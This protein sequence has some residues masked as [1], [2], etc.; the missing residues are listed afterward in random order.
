M[1]LTLNCMLVALLV[2]WASPLFG[3]VDALRQWSDATGKFNVQASLI[4]VRGQDVFLETADGKTM[5][6]PLSRLSQADQDFLK[7]DSNPF[8]EVGGAM[9]NLPATA[10]PAPAPSASDFA[11]SSSAA[12]AADNAPVPW[13]EPWNVDWDQVELM[14]SPFDT[15]WNY[16]PPATVELPFEAK[17]ATLP[18][19]TNFFEGMRRLEINPLAQRAVVGYTVTFSVPKPLSRISIIDLPSGK[20]LQS[21]AIESNMSP[22]AVL[23]DGATVLMQGS[24]K[25]R[26]DYETPDQLQLWRM[27]GK[28]IARSGI[29]Q[30]FAATDDTVGR[31]RMGSDS[32]HV[33]HAMPIAD[34]KIMLLSNERHLACF[35]VRTRQAIW[36]TRLKP[37]YALDYSLDRTQ[38]F[39]LDD[40]TLMVVDPSSGKV[41]SSLSLEGQPRLSWPRISLNPAGNQLLLTYGNDFRVIDLSSGTTGLSGT[42]TTRGPLA[43]NG[44]SFLSDDYA[45]LDNRLLLHLPS[46]I[47]VCEYKDAAQI[48]S[49]GGVEFVGLLGDQGGLVVPTSIPHPKAKETLA[50]AVNDPGVFL[51]HPGVPVSLNVTGVGGEYQAQVEKALRQAAEQAGYKV[52]SNAEISIVAAVSGPTPEGVSYIARGT[53]MINKYTTDVRLVWDGK[54][55]WSRGGSNVPGMLSL[56][57]DQTIQQKLDELG[58]KPNISFFDGVSFPKLLQAPQEGQ[59]GQNSGNA[60]LVSKFTLQGLVDSP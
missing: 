48:T 40:Q 45:L 9:P 60:L 32:S 41:L 55:V 30:P 47:M 14:E 4:A 6:I 53:F 16:T 15:Q 8:E 44:L 22:L 2:A 49:M 29:W 12:Q 39:L 26:E 43:A 46:Q 27:Q 38:L 37:N 10:T 51:I 36:H 17:R 20:S 11:G 57:R 25:E 24:G 28:K 19:K 52:V 59:Q 56:D 3:Q 7:G 54:N 33:N 21:E 5:K 13:S 35:D 34:N 1:K 58:K 50:K 23:N 18:K 42:I 31:R